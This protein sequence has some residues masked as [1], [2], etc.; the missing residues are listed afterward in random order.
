MT[1]AS[2]SQRRAAD[3]G[4]S[5]FVSA[6]AGS[7]KTA[8]LVNRV[9]RL[10]L[11]GA[12]PESLLCVTYTKAAAAE[13][14]TRLF[15]R[16]GEW[17]VAPDEKLRQELADIDAQAADLADARALFAR[18]LE[19]PGG[20]KIQTLHA[21]CESLLR[22][23]PLEADAP[24]GFEVA[25]DATTAALSRRARE[26]VARRS[27]RPP[28]TPLTDAFG[29][30]AVEIDLRGLESLLAEMGAK[31]RALGD[32]LK[33]IHGEDQLAT[34]VWRLCGAAEPQSLDAVRAAILQRV[35]N[36]RW[37]HWAESLSASPNK[38][39]RAL[40]DQM[41]LAAD[42]DLEALFG[43]F[44]TGKGERRAKL[45]TQ[46]ADPGVSAGMEN[47]RDWADE[48]RED[49][50]AAVIAHNTTQILTLGVA[51]NQLFAHEK[52]AHGVL[53]F[54]DLTERARHLLTRDIPQTRWVL[55]RLDGGLNH[56][57]LDE[58]QDTAP[59]Q[60]EILNALSEAFFDGETNTGRPRTLFV[61][62]DEKQSIYAFQGA[63]PERLRVEAAAA[64]GRAREAGRVFANVQLDENFRTTAPILAFV[65]RVCAD[66]EVRHG[67]TPGVGDNIEAFPV[68]HRAQREGPGTVD[69]WA[70]EPAPAKDEPN[71]WWAPVDLP[72]ATDPK[73][74]L[75]ERIAAEVKA[76]VERGERV[77]GRDGPRAARWGDILILV[78]RRGGGLFDHILRELKKAGI[79][80][81]G[82]D[83]LLLTQHGVFADLMALGR[84]ALFPEDDLTLAGLLR[85]P[86]CD[87]DEDALFALAHGRPAGLWAALQAAR[88]AS[89]LAA[90]ALATLEPA[91]AAARALTP[92]DF[93][94]GFLARPDAAGHAMRRRLLTRFGPEAREALDAF[95]NETAR[96]EALGFTHLET[97]LDQMAAVDVEVKRDPEGQ[98]ETVRV[99][100]V[101]GAKGLEAPIV[102][103]PDTTGGKP[104]G[105][106]LMEVPEGGF[107]YSPRRG[108]DCAAAAA[109]RAALEAA[110]EK[111]SAR[112]LY[113][114]L[115]RARDRL[116]I[117][118]VEARQKGGWYETLSRVF[119]GLD[120]REA[121]CDDGAA[122]RRY[123][124]DPQNA[125]RDA[126]A[127]AAPLALPAWLGPAPAEAPAA[128]RLIS[129][130]RLGL[131]A[132]AVLSPLAR[133]GGL[134]RFRRGTLIHR[135]LQL[136]P[137]LD[138][139]RRA[140]HAARILAREQD[141]DPGQRDEIAASALAVLADPQFAELFGPGSQAEVALAGTV[142]G[143]PV[144]GRIDRLLVT[145]TRVLVA[146]FKTNRPAPARIEDA[147]ETYLAQ[148]GAYAALLAEIYPA[149]PIEAALVWTEG[150]RLM[151]VPAALMQQ[152]LAS[153]LA[154]T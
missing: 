59:L 110:A 56:I 80:V 15:Q 5:V 136:L 148:L 98:G 82:A 115:T 154:S 61:V 10:L 127:E 48:A 112:L 133:L 49:W 64:A 128:E 83:R 79:P 40:A 66:P 70:L 3:P 141:L 45:T 88:E 129:A 107:L 142:R 43:I 97:F 19:T 58:A 78:R 104:R 21:F 92:F 20:L 50:F 32:W 139:A 106:A 96:L 71:A 99:M 89:P 13:M 100:T 150:P 28:H 31:R 22:R 94:T 143:L 39:D 62:G 57:L 140:D 113:V 55:Y 144:T 132:P 77:V 2:E 119:D 74:R 25:D 134:G 35:Q 145:E 76:I 14:Q 147:D 153:R 65:D 118:G 51:I 102:I 116:I 17:A 120:A 67:L 9:A 138:P 69:L 8:T 18:A 126:A 122:F 54:A 91:I 33:A 26:A 16:L 41:L 42:G 103:L 95:L 53:D 111:E 137:D 1:A 72:E 114:A 84:F 135:L 81:G 63:V 105:G 60:W 93:Y 4:A 123:G 130:S 7:G 68:H 34:A 23:F 46:K 125:P 101:H 12:A 121:H 131:A 124:D 146:D 152:A 6:N 29:H 75:A 108:E 85:S 73:R 37:R 47:L 149:R 11:T 27:L 87:Y 38:T 90:S 24:P 117:A 86:L 36:L 151:P 30:V 44:Y 52:S 109:A